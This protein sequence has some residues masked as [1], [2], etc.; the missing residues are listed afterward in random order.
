MKVSWDLLDDLT[1][2]RSSLETLANIYVYQATR[3]NVSENL[4]VG[5]G[6]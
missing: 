2:K 1:L 6:L 5:V 3:R 4:K